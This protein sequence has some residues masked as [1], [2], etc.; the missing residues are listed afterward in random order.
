M[1]YIT[2]TNGE[3]VELFKGL[4][5]IKNVKGTRFAFVVAKNL[6]EL[7]RFLQPLEAKAIPS[8]EFQIV[9]A[10]AHKLA[11]A[12]DVNG[13]EELEKEHEDL[14]KQRKEQLAEIERLMLEE[15]KVALEMIKETS[16]PEDLT[17]DQLL[18]I[19]R[20]VKQ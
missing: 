9:A 13:I 17:T 7:G 19:L 4:E 11:E 1:E 15:T 12:E 16:L 8:K 18:P 5:A 10:T 14:I 3:L 2:A 6:K 20:L